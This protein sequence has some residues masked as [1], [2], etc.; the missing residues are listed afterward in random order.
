MN[1]IAA[2]DDTYQHTRCRT[3][4]IKET[5]TTVPNYPTKLTIFKNQASQYWQVR[6]Y[7]NNRVIIRSLKTTDKRDAIRLAKNF[8]DD[9]LL[10]S[11]QNY[12]DSTIQPTRKTHTIEQAVGIMLKSELGKAERDVISKHSYRMTLSRVTKHIVPYFTN[13]PIENITH[14]QIRE[15]FDFLCTKHYKPVT[16]YQYLI[17]LK[18]TL[19]AAHAEGW[20][21]D[22]PY[23]PKIKVTHNARGWFTVNEYLQ[24]MRTTKQLSLLPIAVKPSTHR[25]TRNGL[26]TK[27]DHIPKDMLWLIR[28]MVNSFVRPV[29]IKLIQHKH[30]AIV[31]GEHT[32]LRL[33]LPETKRHKGQVITLPA[34]VRVYENLLHTNH[35]LGLASGDDYLFFPQIRDRQAAIV[36]IEKYFRQILDTAALGRTKDGQKRTLYSLRHSAITFR[37]LYGKNIDLLTLARN[38]RTSIEMIDKY[39]ASGLTAEMNVSMLHS[40]RSL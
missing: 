23:F 11:R 32:Y 7:M 21:S 40:R 28:F 25:N 14:R 8:Y 17:A 4:P 1:L 35:K 16:L 2:N 31:R 33:S 6:C 13:I 12:S 5:V 18:K 3:L 10:S 19:V 29:D 38:A 26:F 20:I 15:F 27:T 9:Y 24:L 22:L 37:L 34:A 36:V 30:V 39:Y